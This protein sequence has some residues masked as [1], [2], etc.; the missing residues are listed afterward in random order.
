MKEIK[1]PNCGRENAARARYCM[2]CGF[3]MKDA[4]PAGGIRETQA[5]PDSGRWNPE[6]AYTRGKGRIIFGILLLV[7]AAAAAAFLLAYNRPPELGMPYGISRTMSAEEVRE[8]MERN[9]FTPLGSASG[10]DFRNQI[11]DTAYVLDEAAEYSMTSVGQGSNAGQICV[12]HAFRE[13]ETGSFR[14][15]GPVFQRLY[16]VLEGLYGTPEKDTLNGMYL[17]RKGKVFLSLH[18]AGTSLVELSWIETN[19]AR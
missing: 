4:E 13:E 12:L 10:S 5:A 6:R 2:F 1:C 16:G 11:Y 14:N 17:W 3:P 9:G 7:F 8:C 15:P 19:A 18:Y